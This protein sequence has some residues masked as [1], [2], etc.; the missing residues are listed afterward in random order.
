M[1]DELWRQVHATPDDDA[2]RAVLADALLAVGDPRG[3]LIALQ[4]QPLDPARA[5]R[6]DQLVEIHG[7]RWLGPLRELANRAQFTRG[8]VS[9]LELYEGLKANH[10]LEQQLAEPMLG[11]VEEL[12][13]GRAHQNVYARVMTALTGLRR[14][15][16]FDQETMVALRKT[17]SPIE[18]V[19]IR[20]SS[21]RPWRGSPIHDIL[22]SCMRHEVRSLGFELGAIDLVLAHPIFPRL[23]AITVGAPL[24]R[25]IPLVH[26]LPNSVAITVAPSPSL[27]PCIAGPLITLGSARLLRIGSQVTVRGWGQWF[28]D[29]LA[30]QGSILEGVHRIEVAASPSAVDR[31]RRA[32]GSIEL[33]TVPEEPRLGYVRAL[34]IRP[35]S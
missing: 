33:V 14:V 10:A 11:T 31:V 35:K 13:A 20:A 1:I 27:E 22:D 15:D 2:I 16:V 28:V 6:I 5:A 17:S 8:C 24:A 12:L 21:R 29:T 30:E 7:V 26:H 3:E 4:L 18:H 25:A 9:R 32:I 34:S 23:E 19:A